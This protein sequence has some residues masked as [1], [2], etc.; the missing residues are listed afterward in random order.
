[1]LCIIDISTL[2]KERAA[3][4]VCRL[5]EVEIDEARLEL[6]AR[7]VPP[8]Y[9]SGVRFKTQP[10]SSCAFRPPS[11]VYERGG[12]DCKQL[13]TWRIA[14]LRE[15][16][17]NAMPRVIWVDSRDGKTVSGL[18]AHMQIRLPD[19][20]VEDPSVNLGMAEL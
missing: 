14:E 3:L 9:K 18:Q 19:N 16:G 2:G 7:K 4:E 5:A 8:I 13:V 11:E 20:T 1:V 10:A 15:N 6:K 17:I 12:G